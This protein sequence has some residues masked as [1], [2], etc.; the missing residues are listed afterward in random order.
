VSFHPLLASTVEGEAFI[1]GR[2]E[3][4]GKETGIGKERESEAKKSNAA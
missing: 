3:G 1:G 4:R 2:G